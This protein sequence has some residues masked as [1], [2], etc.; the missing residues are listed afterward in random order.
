MTNSNNLNGIEHSEP[1]ENSK[2][3]YTKQLKK[4]PEMIRYEKETGKYA[5]WKG[6]ITDDFKKWSKSE[7]KSKEEK[8]RISLYVSKGMKRKWTE[9]AREHGYSTI[10]K[11]IREAVNHFIDEKSRTI[12]GGELKLDKE[13]ISSISH[14]LKEP[15]TSI[16]GYSQFLLESGDKFLNVDTRN[17]IQNIFDSS[18]MLENKIV[19]ILDKISTESEGTDILLIEDDLSTIRL[20]TSYFESK[21]FS[22]KGVISGTKAIEELKISHPKVILLDIIL[23]DLNG[24]DISKMIK[25]DQE[26]KDIPVYLL[27]AIP[28]SEVEKN[29]K[30]CMADGLILK[31]F[32][33]AD[34]EEILTFLNE[35][36]KKSKES[37]KNNQQDK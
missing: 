8:E 24:Y 11:F 10:S 1:N 18:I 28:R 19:N 14:A 13:T 6:E 7:K 35:K 21:G 32:D 37:E 12:R 5:I 23:P 3:N 25:M 16:K 31:P 36:K 29:I 22:C 9:F 4:T 15:L 26:L 30:E 33:F 17:T 20:L 2:I 27:T 34:F